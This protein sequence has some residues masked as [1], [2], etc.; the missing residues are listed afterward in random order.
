MDA[1]ALMDE[2]DPMDEMAMWGAA[3]GQL[4][5]CAAAPGD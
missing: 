5:C 1:I 4:L 3:W 2:M